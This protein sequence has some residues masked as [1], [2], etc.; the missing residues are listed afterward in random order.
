MP[1]SVT[2]RP[3]QNG[4]YNRVTNLPLSITTVIDQ[5][6]PQTIAR[7]ITAIMSEILQEELDKIYAFAVGLGKQAG[8]MLRDAAQLRM[9]GGSG[10]IGQDEHV[11]KDNAVDLVTETDENVEAFIKN[12]I[13][14]K[15]PRHK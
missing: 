5:P 4:S 3:D 15:Y 13:T 14:Q 1:I 2:S 9:D 11:Q 10:A 8:Q 12:Q 7:R 6:L